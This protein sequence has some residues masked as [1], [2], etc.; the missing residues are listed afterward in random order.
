MEKPAAHHAACGWWRRGDQKIS[1][2]TSFADVSLAG[3]STTE[4]LRIALVERRFLPAPH[5]D[6]RSTRRPKDVG[7]SRF[8]RVRVNAGFA[9][10]SYKKTFGRPLRSISGADEAGIRINSGCG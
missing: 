10:N 5:S 6:V 1:T 2:A 3:T 8:G 4:Q 7:T 9:F